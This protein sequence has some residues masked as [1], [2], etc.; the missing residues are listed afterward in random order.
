MK[1]CKLGIISILLVS[2]KMY[3]SIIENKYIF[4]HTSGWLKDQQVQHHCDV[5]I[6]YCCE[7]F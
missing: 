4:A 1:H 2:C 6:M 3:V 5:H 7:Y